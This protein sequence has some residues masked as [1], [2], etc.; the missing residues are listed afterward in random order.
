[1]E[2]KIKISDH[3]FL[4]GFFSADYA[5]GDRAK[6]LVELPALNVL[7]CA[8]AEG[9]I[10]IK[11]INESRGTA[12]YYE[13]QTAILI[14]ERINPM[15]NEPYDVTFTERVIDAAGRIIE[16]CEDLGALIERA[17]SEYPEFI[18]HEPTLTA[19]RAPAVA[20]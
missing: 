4:N 20:A 15:T 2:T 6:T 9:L 10:R 11:S 14:E 16:T 1:M 7:R 12:P 5:D 13:R 19:G 18:C 3:G 17:E 8:E